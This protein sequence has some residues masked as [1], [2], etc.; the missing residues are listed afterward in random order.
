[1]VKVATI[2]VVGIRSC[3]QELCSRQ[4]AQGQCSGSDD[5]VVG[6]AQVNG[7]YASRRGAKARTAAQ[8][9]GRHHDVASM[10]WLCMRYLKTPGLIKPSGPH[11]QL[12][13]A[14]TVQQVAKGRFH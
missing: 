14:I 8:R 12:S 2:C 4:C 10:V 3:V 5:A 13:L 7:A 6:A 11:F 1:M 9:F